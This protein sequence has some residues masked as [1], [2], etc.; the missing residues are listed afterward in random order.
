MWN[1][2]SLARA[3]GPMLFILHSNQVTQLGIRVCA[4][5]ALKMY[6]RKNSKDGRP[7]KTKRK[8]SIFRT[9]FICMSIPILLRLDE[10]FKLGIFNAFCHFVHSRFATQPEHSP[11]YSDKA[12]DIDS[13]HDNRIYAT[14]LKLGKNESRVLLTLCTAVKNNV[15]FILEWIEYMRLQGVER[16]VIA[17][18]ESSDNLSLL[19]AFYQQVDPSFDLR[20]FPRLQ[21]GLEYGGQARNLQHCVDTFRN[22]SEWIL[23]SDTD[24]FLYSPSHG[25]LFQMLK[26]LP[27]LEASHGVLVDSIYAQCYR[28]GSSGRR[29]RFRYRLTREPDGTVAHRSDCGGAGGRL[30]LMLRQTRRGPFPDSYRADQTEEA[31]LCARLQAGRPIE[32]RLFLFVFFSTALGSGFFG[33]RFAFVFDHSRFR[34]SSI[35]PRRAR[36]AAQQHQAGG[37]PH[38][39][40]PWT[41]PRRPPP[42]ARRRTV[43]PASPATPDQARPSF[44]LPTSTRS[45]GQQLAPATLR[46]WFRE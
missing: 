16:I 11:A 42:S 8:I 6:F 36:P 23:V 15:H 21:N 12:E 26:A 3:T 27:A 20:V 39:T 33:I 43:T 5:S 37:E 7:M 30:D 13:F 45:A 9:F 34:F 22:L 28:F 32:I 44:T 17:D 4:D 29:R 41:R 38:R 35:F 10:F 40:R 25:T 14:T 19:S 46:E 1:C 31:A 2:P 24:E 18:D